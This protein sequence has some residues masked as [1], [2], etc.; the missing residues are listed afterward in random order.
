MV[1]KAEDHVT[2][3]VRNEV[4]IWSGK[5][6]TWG[7]RKRTGS[8]WNYKNLTAGLPSESLP[9]VMHITEA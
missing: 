9:S 6:E 5:G 4:G 1:A 8:R 3:E 2:W 7:E